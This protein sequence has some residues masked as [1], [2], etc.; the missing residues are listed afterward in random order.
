[1]TAGVMT[2]RVGVFGAGGHA[3]VVIDVLRSAGAEVVAC[4]VPGGSGE[5]CGVPVIDEADGVA[6]VFADGSVLAFVAI[7][8]NAARRGLAGRLRRRGLAFANAVS[9]S[10][11]LAADVAL[12]TGILIG[13][14]AAINTA[15]VLGDDV[16]VNTGATV[17]HDNVIGDG[18][19][20]APGSHLAGTVTVG[21]GAFLGIGTSVIPGIRIGAGAIL[22][23]G[24]VVIRDVPA[25]ARAWGNPARVRE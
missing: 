16:I 2:A 8:D 20:I 17:D 15:T 4:L 22:G 10:A 12:G 11:Y 24:S 3:K 9:P 13:P 1:M 14:N 5:F 19:H 25:G 18:V 7:G 23:A 6:T 21:D